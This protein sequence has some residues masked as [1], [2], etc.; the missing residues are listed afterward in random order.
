[1]KLRF[2]IVL[3]LWIGSIY[4]IAQAPNTQIYLFDWVKA[5]DGNIALHSPKIL[6]AFNSKGYNNQSQLMP[7]AIL[8]FLVENQINKGLPTI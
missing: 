1:M 7:L 5:P 2:S 4:T 3:C 6:T 8:P